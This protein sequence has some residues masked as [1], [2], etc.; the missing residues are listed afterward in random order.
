MPSPTT[1]NDRTE[2]VLETENKHAWLRSILHSSLMPE[3]DG[4]VTSKLSLAVE[5]GLFLR[6]G[7]SVGWQCARPRCGIISQ[8]MQLLA[9]VLS[10][11][12]SHHIFSEASCR[13]DRMQHLPFILCQK[14]PVLVL[15]TRKELGA[16]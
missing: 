4:E 15:A 10:A 11:P 5:G 9:L 12:L 16:H 6:H 13:C 1:V 8:S 7:L 2:G 3:V 14:S